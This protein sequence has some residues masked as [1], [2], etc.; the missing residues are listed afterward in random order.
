MPLINFSLNLSY[1][2][3][4]I[5][6]KKNV[7]KSNCKLESIIIQERLIEEAIANRDTAQVRYH[8][9]NSIM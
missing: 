3:I 2:H 5:S 9:L 7:A 8:Y 6:I 1:F 4:N